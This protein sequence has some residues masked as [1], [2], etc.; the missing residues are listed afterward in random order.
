MKTFVERYTWDEF[1]LIEDIRRVLRI[2]R[3]SRFIGNYQPYQVRANES[4]LQL[5]FVS[6]LSK[7][8]VS[9]DLYLRNLKLDFAIQVWEIAQDLTKKKYFDY[10]EYSWLKTKDP[11]K[12]LTFTS[13]NRQ[14]AEKY[15]YQM[16]EEVCNDEKI[17]SSESATFKRHEHIG[18][19]TDDLRL[20]VFLNENKITDEIREKVY[21]QYTT[22]EKNYA[23]DLKNQRFSFEE[24][25][26]FFVYCDNHLLSLLNA[27]DGNKETTEQEKLLFSSADNSDLDGILNAV[28]QGADINAIDTNGE[29]AFTK[30][31]QNFNDK[32][33]NEERKIE[34][35]ILIEQT[36]LIATKMLELGADINLF[37]YNGINALQQI[38]YSHNPTLMKFLLDKGASPNINYFPEDGQDY[39][40]STALD[41][42]LSDYYVDDD[43]ENLNQC[44]TLLKNAGAE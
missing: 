21:K 28:K 37:G 1:Q 33:Y 38:A 7:Q 12:E 41:T 18:Y 20:E 40:K 16:L 4:L 36:I 5:G 22:G 35:K 8:E 2:T 14:K 29:T 43:E 44:E 6:H 32:F 34:E 25:K 13:K 11:F 17:V 42:I 26:D 9:I 24:I 39:I 23:F 10:L 30:V 15:F 27:E 19:D 31:F 3:N